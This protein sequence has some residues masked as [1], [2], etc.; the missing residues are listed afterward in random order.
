MSAVA[1]ERERTRTSRWSVKDLNVWYGHFQALT[2]RH[3]WTSREADHGAHRPVRLRQEH[4]PALPQPHERPDPRLP[5]RGRGGVLD[6]ENI[7]ATDVD[8]VEVRRRIGMVFQKPN[9]FPK[10]IYDNVAFGARINGIKGSMDELVERALR[11]AALWDEVKDELNESPASRSP[12]ASSSASASPARS[13]S[14]R[15]SSSWTS[16]APR[17]T[18]SPR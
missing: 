4:A 8:P 14:S 18:R 3:A 13:P 5:R 15:T 16:R 9:P 6:G 7:Y 10:S 1:D 2:Q 12:A 17:S 11:Q